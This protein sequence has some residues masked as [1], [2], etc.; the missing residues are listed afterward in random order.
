MAG[1]MRT[2]REYIAYH[3]RNRAYLPPA[4][5]VP[6]IVD[7]YADSKY[8]QTPLAKRALDV[9]FILELNCT[10]PTH[11]HEF[12][13]LDCQAIALQARH[14]LLT[15]AKP[16]HAFMRYVRLYH[17]CL[18]ASSPPSGAWSLHYQTAHRLVSSEAEE[19]SALA[20]ASA[21]R[22]TFV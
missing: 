22:G 3:N 19:S 10:S 6:A 7:R 11:P 4:F 13:T 9:F 12:I 8:I 15:M 17:D 2:L 5:G 18:C 16:G 21:S 20:H 1:A 14:L